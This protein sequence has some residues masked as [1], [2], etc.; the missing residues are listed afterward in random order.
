MPRAFIAGCCCGGTE[1]CA[2]CEGEATNFMTLDLSGVTYDTLYEANLSDV[3]VGEFEYPS[4]DLANCIATRSIRIDS[5]DAGVNDTHCLMRS[6][7]DPCRWYKLGG[8]V[9]VSLYAGCD[10]TT[11]I[12]TITAPVL[13]EI[14]VLPA[15]GATPRRINILVWIQCYEFE[16]LSGFAPRLAF[17]GATSTSTD[18]SDSLFCLNETTLANETIIIEFSGTISSFGLDGTAIVTPGGGPCTYDFPFA[19]S[20]QTASL[21]STVTVVITGCSDLNGTYT[22]ANL[23]GLYY[24]QSEDESMTFTLQCVDAG[25]YSFWRLDVEADDGYRFQTRTL[26][27]NAPPTGTF[28]P[29]PTFDSGAPCTSA[30]IS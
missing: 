26:S 18:S 23:D 11:L 24:F 20:C 6:P 27:V 22:L 13:Y 29:C 14:R 4:E 7:A 8:D 15:V 5:T 9:T 17:F 30:V 2:E 16:S 19:P 1:P 10:Y 3:C 28:L 25:G 12:T 21:P